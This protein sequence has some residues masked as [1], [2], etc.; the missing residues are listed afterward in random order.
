MELNSYKI[1]ESKMEK[2]SKMFNGKE[3]PIVTDTNDL[4]KKSTECF[5][6][7]IN[8]HKNKA[9]ADQM[10]NTAF[11]FGNDCFGLASNQVNEYKRI[12]LMI[13]PLAETLSFSLMCN[14][15]I[16]CK[17]GGVKAMYEGYLSRPGEKRIKVRR[18]KA[19]KVKWQTVTGAGKQRE[20]KG[21]LARAIMHGIDHLNGVLI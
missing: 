7:E 12:I 21:I 8:V 3:Y 5:F 2:N 10:L 16:Y 6:D 17:K 1:K 9:I 18:H 11:A 19:I 13:N 20:F 4:S 15:I 14:P